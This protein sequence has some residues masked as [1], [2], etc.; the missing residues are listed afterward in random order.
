MRRL[1]LLLGTA[2]A[3]ASAPSASAWS[4]PLSG[5][6]LRPY[7]L[8]SDAYAAG[9]HR[10][11]DVAGTTGDQVR[12]PASGFVTFAGVV[13]THGKTVTLRTDGGYLVSLTHLGD[14]SVSKG[15]S[16]TEGDQ[17]GSAGQSGDSEWPT[18]YVHLGIRVSDAADAYVDPMT[19][20]PPRAVAPPPTVVEP[21]GAPA[22][23]APSVSSQQPPPPL[24]PS[25]APVPEGPA[26]L[27]APSEPAEQ[28][29]VVASSGQPG[30]SVAQP[31]GE[32][33]T[34]ATEG[35]SIA[36]P[37]PASGP[38]R[39]GGFR[40]RVAGDGRPARVVGDRPVSG[41]S[42]VRRSVP[43]TGGTRVVVSG[44]PDTPSLSAVAPSGSDELGARSRPMGR[45]DRSAAAPP[46]PTPAD[47]RA[48]VVPR[49]ALASALP[50]PASGATSSTVRVAG[51]ER[52]HA[53][54][55]SHD[56]GRD[57]GVLGGVAVLGA[58]LA[59]TRRR[60]RRL[61]VARMMGRDGGASEDPGRR[62]MAVRERT[63]AYRPRGGLRGSLRHLCPL[64]QAAWKRGLDGQRYR[65]AR[66]TDHG[67][68][69]S[70]R[71]LPA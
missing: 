49:A 56:L 52:A 68:R 37:F 28:P 40:A 60:T 64:P 16:V 27:I 59:I 35:V 26:S 31:A 67:R 20:L 45:S 38:Q 30:A 24:A 58:A 23:I 22:V 42:V 47:T 10:G 32:T 17:V 1:A 25:V 4:W 63:A 8:G 3:L 2:I 14:V 39:S 41:T 50:D 29:T 13:P 66:H 57:V 11:V 18:P 69:R 15:A 61:A 36:P 53:G 70:G 7:S 34:V 19:L 62:G 12:A 65:R 5:D 55:P 33:H 48:A 6:V 71:H 46:L 9:Q 44:T 43:S 54:S 21:A 51:L